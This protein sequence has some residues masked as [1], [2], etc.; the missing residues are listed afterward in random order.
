MTQEGR[1]DSIKDYDGSRNFGQDSTLQLGLDDS[2][3]QVDSYYNTQTHVHTIDDSRADI[4][5]REKQKKEKA[6]KE[7][8]DNFLAK[9]YDNKDKP[10]SGC[11]IFKESASL[12]LPT[13]FTFSDFF[14]CSLALK[15]ILIYTLPEGGESTSIVA[16]TAFHGAYFSILM[17]SINL[18]ILETQGITGTQAYSKGLFKQLNKICRQALLSCMICFVV[19]TVIPYFWIDPVLKLIGVEDLQLEI[20]KELILFSFPAMALRVLN[21]NIKVFIQNQDKLSVVGISN[22]IVFI[23]W[24]PITFFLVNSM[25]NKSEAYGMGL[26]VYEVICLLAN[27]Y[28]IFKKCNKKCLNSSEP[29]WKGFGKFFWYSF[30]I[31]LSGWLIY[32][33][34]DAMTVMLQQRKDESQVAAYSIF[35]NIT[36]VIVSLIAGFYVYARNILNY[37]L[38]QKRTDEA[39][40]LFKRFYWIYLYF[41]LLMMVVISGMLLST[42]LSKL[43]EDQ[44]LKHWLL[45]STPFVFGIGLCILQ[46]IF[47][48]KGLMSIGYLKF[49]II[50]QFIELLRLPSSYYLCITLEMGLLGILLMDQAFNA[51]KVVLFSMIALSKADWSKAKTL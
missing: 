16:A 30:K 7:E 27:F 34:L 35:Y 50:F 43:I 33:F 36:M 29:L 10:P 21:D 18:G 13:S 46:T 17:Q 4:S 41:N 2:V 38:G 25:D 40:D 19:L 5:F 45:V 1:Y 14:L 15:F 8:D 32:V 6:K 3:T 51:V 26:L 22:F 9:K 42:C 20:V 28:I 48:S 31:S 37:F 11:E 47:A 24:V 44:N 12:G 49:Q 23:I 39:K